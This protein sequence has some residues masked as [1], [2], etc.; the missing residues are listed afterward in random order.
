M[1]MAS[2]AWASTVS[3]RLQSAAASITADG[4]S[5]VATTSVSAGPPQPATQ[6]KSSAAVATLW[7]LEG[8]VVVERA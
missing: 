6:A 1:L 8:T 5:E 2:R 4:F 7:A 3:I